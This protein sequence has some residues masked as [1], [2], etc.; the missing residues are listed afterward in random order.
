MHSKFPPQI[1]AYH[2]FYLFE[3]FECFETV[4]YSDL[5]NK[6]LTNKID[7]KYRDVTDYKK[8]SPH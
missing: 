7:G 5:L 6:Y 1:Y 4:S 8:K 3:N 2:I